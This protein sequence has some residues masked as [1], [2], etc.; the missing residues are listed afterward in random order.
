MKILA[1]GCLHGDQKLIKK[2]AKQADDENVDLV[3][4]AGDLTFAEQST[5]NIVGPFI[6]K[7]RKVLLVPGNHEAVATVDFLADL[8]GATNLHG[9][10][11]LHKN[12]GFFGCSGANIG[13]HQLP[14]TEIY[15]LL[16][17]GFQK[18]KDSKVKI[19]VTHVHPSGTLMEKL[20]NFVHPSTG[21]RKAIDK[22]KPDI[23]FCSHVHEAEG[24]EEKIGKTKIINVCRTGKIINI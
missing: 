22:F 15:N 4:L 20:S 10:S 14:E 19:M 21:V 6:K 8:Y 12:V 23:L 7:N 18:V 5:K 16:K 24:I 17:K 3:V 11:I 9:S 13:M 1:A 2:L